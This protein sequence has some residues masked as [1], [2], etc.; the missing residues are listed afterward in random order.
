MPAPL[1]S[2]VIPTYNRAQMVVDAV[3]SALGQTFTEIEV[4]VVDDGSRDDTQKQ[5]ARFKDRIKV[6]TQQN[7]GVSAARNTGINCAIGKYIAFLDSDDVW[8]PRKLEIQLSHFHQHCD[9]ALLACRSGR[10]SDEMALG[11]WPAPSASS[12]QRIGLEEL[13]LRSRFA[14]SGVMVK[15]A[16]LKSVGGFDETLRS[17]EDRQL[18][19][20]IASVASVRMQDIELFY[21]RGERHSHLSGQAIWTDQNSRV[22]IDRIFRELPALQDRW[23]LKR[24]ALSRAAYEAALLFKDAG[25]RSIAYRRVG[26]SLWLWPFPSGFR[27]DPRYKTLISMLLNGSSSQTRRGSSM[28]EHRFCKADVV[29]STPTLG[30]SGQIDSRP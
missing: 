23:V 12:S 17:S 3:L 5:L 21:S 15:N 19:I 18:W 13:A 2:V 4:I 6:L 26:K 8:H 24:R 28:A 10:F 29:G 30:F 9:A 20:R 1:V 7:Q 11:E 16:L 22:M 14:T 27:I 25:K